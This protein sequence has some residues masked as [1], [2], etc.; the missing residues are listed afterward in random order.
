[1]N[2]HILA[3]VYVLLTHFTSFN[4]E[5]RSKPELGLKGT[6]FLNDFFNA[7]IFTI[8]RRACRFAR[9]NHSWK[10]T[11]EVKTHLSFPF[12]EI[13]NFFGIKNLQMRPQNSAKYFKKVLAIILADGICENCLSFLYTSVHFCWPTNKLFYS[14]LGYDLSRSD[15]TKFYMENGEIYIVEEPL[16]TRPLVDTTNT[17][18]PRLGLHFQ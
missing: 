16:H 15:E 7:N 18:V 1:M 10:R 11:A 8:F 14:N 13:L 9:G 12:Y 17:Q 5:P 6:Y 2:D 4:F 3:I